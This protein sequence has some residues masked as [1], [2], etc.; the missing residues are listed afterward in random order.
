M[1]DASLALTNTDELE[2][3]ELTHFQDGK[4][5]ADGLVCEDGTFIER[6]KPEPR[7]GLTEEDEITIS[8]WVE[9]YKRDHDHIDVG[10]IKMFCT[11]AYRH[12]EACEK[13]VNDQKEKMKNMTKEERIEMSKRNPFEDLE[14]EFE[15][16][17]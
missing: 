13:Y 4:M 17:N 15:R 5:T 1:T 16:V 8:R 2:V 3:P 14:K 11:W 7:P 10:L 6:A 12:P 9:D